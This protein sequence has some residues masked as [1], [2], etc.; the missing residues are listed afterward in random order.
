M[1]INRVQ[2]F[3]RG[4]SHHVH[5]YRPAAGELEYPT[6]NCPFSVDFQKWQL[7]A[8]TQNPL[9]DWQLPPGVAIDIG[10]R[11]PL[12]IQ[13]HFVN[14]GA[15]DVKGGARA[16]M[17]LYPVDPST[18]TAYGGA[19]FGQDRTVAVPPG[20]TTLISRCAMTGQG[21]A[22]HDMTIMALTGHY[23]FRGVEFQ[24]YRVFADGSL[25]EL[26]YQHQGYDDPSFRTYPDTDPLVLKAGEGI[27]WWCRYRN[28]TGETFKFGA[29]TAMNEH[30]N[31]FGFYTPTD[32]P[33]EA[34]ACIHR[35]ITVNGVEQDDTIRCGLDGVECPPPPPPPPA[36]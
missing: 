1:A 21:A 7:V 17:K 13:T 12:M 24:V 34:M 33:Q 8:A 23:H 10:P 18:V 35:K 15:L 3:V 16:K 14:T 28:D 11:Q 27:E 9:L 4:G 20:D 29:N 30:C 25:G 32:T 26:I 6:K 2:M 5:L 36:P 19:L 22:A 31:L